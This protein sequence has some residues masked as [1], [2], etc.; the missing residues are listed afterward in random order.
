MMRLKAWLAGVAICFFIKESYGAFVS[1]SF[2]EHMFGRILKLFCYSITLFDDEYHTVSVLQ[3]SAS[4]LEEIGVP[5]SN[6]N[7]NE[8]GKGSVAPTALKP[9]KRSSTF[10]IVAGI[11]S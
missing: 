6:N 3:A 2:Q 11:S 10:Y 1:I 8:W 7:N 5:P 9:S 4:V